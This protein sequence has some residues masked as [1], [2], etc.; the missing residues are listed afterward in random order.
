[1]TP[2]LR[3]AAFFGW[4]LVSESLLAASQVSYERGA[5]S[6]GVGQYL[7]AASQPRHSISGDRLPSHHFTFRLQSC[8]GCSGPQALIATGSRVWYW[9]SSSCALL[10]RRLR[11]PGP[12]LTQTKLGPSVVR[13]RVG[14]CA[15]GS[16]PSFVAWSPRQSVFT[17]WT[18]ASARFSGP[19]REASVLA[20]LFVSVSSVRQAGRLGA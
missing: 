10:L 13:S 6:P 20:F 19:T 1:M 8:R 16:A 9:S 17:A 11:S 4:L 18:F 2:L 5:S 7:A 14:P 12:I 3:I 15:P